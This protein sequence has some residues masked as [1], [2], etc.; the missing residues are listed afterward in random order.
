MRNSKIVLGFIFGIA[1]IAAQTASAAGPMVPLDQRQTNN[2]NADGVVY[3]GGP[4]LAQVK[5][6]A[7]F[8]G[9]NVDAQVKSD[10]GGFYA[11]AVKSNYMDWLKIYN[12]SGSGMDGRQG[13]HQF[14]GR[15]TFA[16]D[17]TLTPANVGTK[18]DKKDVEAELVHQM[19][20]GKLPK[21]D[22]N[23]LFMVHFPAGITL[24]ASGQD[25]CAAW[26][27]D[28]EYFSTPKYGNVAYAMM[29]DIGGGCF[30]CNFSSTSFDSMTTIASHELIEAVTD[31]LCPDMSITKPLFPAAWMGTDEQEVGDLCV[32]QLT[33]LQAGTRAYT[34]QKIWDQS[35]K[36]CQNAKYSSP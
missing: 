30:G 19:D 4:V 11:A 1:M 28:H 34:V 8:W 9:P 21:A 31:P 35:I 13:T 12:T 7:V 3:Y 20:L 16:G 14:I 6:Y 27:G 26:C 2:A 18:L 5:V 10:I 25:S 15:G 36:G 32:E 24:S 22:A 17:I 33:T 29:P 23:T